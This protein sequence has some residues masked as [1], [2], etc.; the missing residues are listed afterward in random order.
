MTCF[1]FGFYGLR[2]FQ[3]CKGVFRNRGVNGGYRKNALACPLVTR[4]T[5]KDSRPPC[6]RSFRSLLLVG[7]GVVINRLSRRYPRIVF[8][9]TITTGNALLQQ[10]RNRD[11]ELGFDPLS[12]PVGDEDI[13]MEAVH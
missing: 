11:I 7:G 3:V 2:N 1:A 8:N 5:P 6:R 12:E 4:N 9:A 13:D 10:L